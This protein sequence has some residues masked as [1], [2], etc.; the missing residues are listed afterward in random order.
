MYSTGTKASWSFSAALR[1]HQ[2]HRTTMKQWNANIGAV[3]TASSSH[4]EV[5]VWR[6]CQ[7][8]HAPGGSINSSAVAVMAESSRA[9]KVALRADVILTRYF[10]SPTKGATWDIERG[11]QAPHKISQG[12][13]VFGSHSGD[14][15]SRY[16]AG[17]NIIEIN[18]GLQ[19]LRL[20]VGHSK[21]FELQRSA[22]A[23]TLRGRRGRKWVVSACRERRPRR[24]ARN[25]ER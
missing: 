20:F 7:P 21:S 16:A 4:N 25:T 10:A 9:I 1:K 23:V 8:G 24:D 22:K 5:E 12:Q 6:R 2:F 11:S 3:H 17:L 18:W 14:T 15:C 19:L 13:F